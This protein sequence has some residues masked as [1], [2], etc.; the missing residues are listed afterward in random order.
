MGVSTKYQSYYT[1]SEPILDYMTQ[2]LDIKS[3][4]AIF[5]PC[6]GNG[7]FVDKILKQI[8]SANISIFELDPNAVATLQDK[9]ACLNNISIKSTDTLLDNCI[10]NRLITFDKIIG[11]PPYGARN[12]DNKKN[13]LAKLYPGLYT[14]E[15]YTLF[16]FAC[17]KCLNEGGM[18]SFIVPDTFL[19]LHRHLAIRQFI[20]QHTQIKELS[21]FPSSYFPGVDFGYANLCIITLQKS[22]NIASNLSNKFTIRT[23]FTSV[24]DLYF[25]H[26]GTHQEF[27]QSDILNNPAS[28]FFFNSNSRINSLVNDITI[29]TIGDI[30]DCVTGFYSG[31]DKIYL[32]PANPKII[33]KDD[34]IFGNS[35][36]ETGETGETDDETPK[37]GVSSPSLHPLK[38]ETPDED[39]TPD[40]ET[41]ETGETDQSEKPEEDSPAEP[42]S[43]TLGLIAVIPAVVSLESTAVLLEINATNLRQV[44]CQAGQISAVL[45]TSLVIENGITAKIDE[46][47]G[48]SRGFFPTRSDPRAT[49]AV[50]SE[51]RLF[52]VLCGR[53]ASCRTAVPVHRDSEE[54]N[55]VPH[56]VGVAD[57]GIP[58]DHIEDDLLRPSI[59]PSGNRGL[60]AV[61]Q[62]MWKRGNVVTGSERDQVDAGVGADAEARGVRR[63][64][65]TREILREM[66]DFR[67]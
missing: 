50:I 32:R 44:W 17:I 38:L 42:T 51:P 12:D 49:P 28:A 41:G 39:E 26:K 2:I 21:L 60:L 67:R 30:A 31:N 9:Y 23:G 54:G 48:S 22:S 40:G 1:K 55:S 10:V 43:A 7:A 4:D 20:L 52:C 5:E 62:G 35:E 33:A 65:R 16:L 25:P 56:G 29:R 64:G 46:G 14:K 57:V 66:L 37:R 61:R 47:D 6:G 8:P 53:A 15:S 3:T 36:D 34:D 63:C 59:E 27:T 24:N 45:P 18:L 11:N 13:E 19:S 58:A